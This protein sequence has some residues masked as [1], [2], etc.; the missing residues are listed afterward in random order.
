MVHL[1]DEQPP[2]HK[3]FD[4]RHQLTKEYHRLFFHQPNKAWLK[5]NQGRSPNFEPEPHIPFADVEDIL[6]HPDVED[7]RLFADAHSLNSARING[8]T[9]SYAGLNLDDAPPFNFDAI[10]P[11]WEPIVRAQMKDKK[12]IDSRE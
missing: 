10:W 1:L 11:R 6:Q 2:S 3:D 5:E 7:E 9:R 12:G 8:A 4:R